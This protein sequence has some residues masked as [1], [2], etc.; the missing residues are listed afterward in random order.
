MVFWLFFSGV[1]TIIEGVNVFLNIAS[2]RRC[3]K[4]FKLIVYLGTRAYLVVLF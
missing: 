1:M 2:G 3:I 4:V